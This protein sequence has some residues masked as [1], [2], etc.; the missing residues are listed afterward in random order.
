MGAS[1]LGERQPFPTTAG[2]RRRYFLTNADLQVLGA[3]A[4]ASCAWRTLPDSP[5]LAGYHLDLERS[6]AENLRSVAGLGLL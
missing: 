2:A 4:P 3:E 1:P 6:R 5:V